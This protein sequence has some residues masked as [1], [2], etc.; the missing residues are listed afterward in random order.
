MWF[1]LYLKQGTLVD[2]AGMTKA[3]VLVKDGKMAGLV[4]G[5]ESPQALQVIDASGKYILPG[6]IDVHV[7][8]RTPG[9]TYKEDFRS[10]SLAAACGGITTV[11][12][13]PNVVPPTTGTGELVA[14]IEQ[15]AGTSWVDYGL[16]AALTYENV[17]RLED[18]A[19][20]GAAGFKLFFNEI[21]NPLAPDGELKAAFN[22]IA[23]TG[24]CSAVHAELGR[25]IADGIERLKAEGRTDPLAHLESRPSRVEAEAI[26]RLVALAGGTGVKLHICHLSSKEGAEQ[27][28]RAREEGIDISAETAPHY[29]LL[30][31]TMMEG[32]GPLLKVNPPLRSPRHKEALWAALAEGVIGILASD[33]APHTREEKF[34]S[35]IWEAVSGFCGVETLVPLMLNEVNRGHLSLKELAALLSE[36]PARRYNLYPRK[37]AIARGADADFT[38]VDLEADK[39]LAA[40]ELHSKSKITPYEG[41]RIKGVP[42][43]TIVGGRVVMEDGIICGEPEGKMIRPMI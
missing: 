36:N 27:V 11:I 21:E 17:N 31:S 41:Y 13:M 24:L 26:G 23:G 16:M 18:L 7:H 12:D 30:D 38:L 33:H 8:F 6:L 9:L 40:E 32:L 5:D 20:A 10:G 22:I 37:G 19:R 25:A 2:S 34:K 43:A 15:I 4:R 42:A 1:D 3:G 14:K 35:S 39:T 29:L 28:R